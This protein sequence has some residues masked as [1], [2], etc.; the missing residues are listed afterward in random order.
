M[1][2]YYE[3]VAR[4]PCAINPT[5]GHVILHHIR[6]M[7]SLKTGKTMPRSHKTLAR[8]A[9]IPLCPDCHDKVHNVGENEWFAE[10]GHPENYAMSVCIRLMAEYIELAE[11]QL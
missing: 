11:K 8:Y 1:V 2:R 3:F 10:N 6:G 7:A 5:H 4:K 9:V